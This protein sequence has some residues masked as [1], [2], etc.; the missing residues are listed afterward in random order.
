MSYWRSF[1]NHNCTHLSSSAPKLC[2][3]TA[4]T[5]SPVGSD[6]RGGGISHWCKW[7]N[8]GAG[9]FCQVFDVLSAAAVGDTRADLEGRGLCVGW[10][11]P[12]PS[13][14][15]G[16]LCPPF[17]MQS[18]DTYMFHSSQQALVFVIDELIPF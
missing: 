1:G 17:L 12:S 9:I 10:I 14:L 7:S 8:V 11:Y 6:G 13:S 18:S 3:L 16:H 15:K 4:G 2:C 5:A